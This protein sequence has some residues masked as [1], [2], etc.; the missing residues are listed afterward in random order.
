MSSPAIMIDHRRVRLGPRL[1]KGGEGEVYSLEN[2][3]AH[4]VKLY[5]VAD[6]SEREHKV[7]AMI[8]TGMARQAPQVAF[9]L[10]VVRDESGRFTGFL[11]KNVLEHKPLHE[12]YS[13]GS[14]KLH[15]PQA[16]YRFL[17]RTAQNIAKAIASVHALGCVIGD[18]NQSS[19]L[20]SKGATVALIDSDSFQVSSGSQKYLCRVGV[21]EYTPP[22]L[23]GTSLVKT[24][25]TPNHDAFGLA[26]V[27]FQL[28]FM[29]R[30]P[31]VGSVRRG[32][33]PALHDSIRDFRFVY[34]DQRDVG[35]D[36]PPGTPAL[37]EFPR[38][39]AL[40]F[41]AA[42]GRTTQD[43]RP[44]AQAWIE[45][46]TELEKSLV[47]CSHDKLHW[48][49][50]EASECP[51]CAMERE[52]GALLFVSAVP[53]ER[54]LSPFDPGAGGFNLAA[55]W[56][57]IATF[58][59]QRLAP[60]LPKASPRPSASARVA[61]WLGRSYVSKLRRNY[62]DVEQQ[63][64]AAADGWRTRTGV[65]AIE[66]LFQEL[67]AANASYE[68]LASE[69]KAQFEAYARERRE[70]Q[71]LAYLA[72]F[73]I[74]RA[75]LRGIGPPEE[76]ALASFGIETA[77]D[78]IASKILRVPGLGSDIS[79]ALYD[80]RKRIEKQFVYDAKENELDRQELARIRATI[81]HRAAYLRRM[82]L[83]GRSNLD[84]AFSRL[85]GSLA[86]VDTE[87]ARLHL[88][89]AQLRTDLSYLGIDPATLSALAANSTHLAMAATRGAAKPAFPS[90]GVAATSS[91]AVKCPRCGSP[92]VRRIARH[93]GAAGRQF[94]GCTRF[95][96]CKGTII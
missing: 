61:R 71:L 3:E 78:V 23:Q 19:I 31:F 63:W 10:S 92:M 94:W 21:P 65:A 44:S 68:S 13:P 1:G 49:P 37:S 22:E 54:I 18:I 25:R 40:A 14:R 16:D 7:E 82:L 62:F 17:I 53:A 57:Q 81:E 15:F 12:V 47:Q 50:A 45:I 76:T 84:S 58:N 73:E 69:E 56:R 43:S 77:A 83:A 72:R 89:R 60:L 4:A 24:A 27:I 8:R 79:T 80:W 87:L 75:R 20:V 64:L 6:L 67:R 88:L 91:S 28:L 29:G 48:Y 85:G 93:R 46:L 70:R 55:V 74:S 30:H 41:E 33:I 86:V 36:Q 52:L 26:I 11:M 90:V 39:T 38:S 2:D 5:T 32:D 59:M 66:D 35:M 96:L 34:T 42:F 51:W 9:P 95:P